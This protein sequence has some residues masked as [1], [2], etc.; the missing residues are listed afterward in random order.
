MSSDLDRR[1]S[2]QRWGQKTTC[3]A[4]LGMSNGTWAEAAE[5]DA[6][7][8]TT[9]CGHTMDW[10]SPHISALFCSCQMHY[11]A[12]TISCIWY[13]CH[14]HH[15]GLCIMESAHEAILSHVCY[16]SF[17]ISHIP[18]QDIYHSP[19]HWPCSHF[20]PDAWRSVVS[21]PF[22]RCKQYACPTWCCCPQCWT[23]GLSNCQRG[24]IPHLDQ[25]PRTVQYHVCQD[26]EVV[27]LV[28]QTP[29]Y[30]DWRIQVAGR[31]AGAQVL[32]GFKT[33]NSFNLATSLAVNNARSPGG[34]GKI[35]S[36]KQ[37]GPIVQKG[38]SCHVVESTSGPTWLRGMTNSGN[39]SGPN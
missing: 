24:W 11:H 10:H 35:E 38:T 32:G 7:E 23:D 18:C 9:F 2:V 37:K 21:A 19:C 30:P 39:N 28:Q 34:P 14:T 27:H 29:P 3:K 1:T 33:P 13:C 8:C 6:Q 36:M 12:H 31:V 25:S 15:H 16:H 20:S 5:A 4:W 26:R 17:W 22:L